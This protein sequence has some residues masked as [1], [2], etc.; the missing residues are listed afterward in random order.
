MARSA[1]YSRTRAATGDTVSA[2]A[3]GLSILQCFADAPAALSHGELARRTGIPK[4]TVTRLVATLVTHGL[5][6]PER[7]S[8]RYRLAAGVMTLA[9][10]FL[11]GLDTRAAARPHMQALAEEFDAS[12]YLAV[13]DAPEMVIIEACR[14]R[15]AALTSRL[16]IGSRVM[17]LRS[18]LG[19]AYLGGLDPAARESLLRD[20]R[21]RAGN[22]WRRESAGLDA[23]LRDAALRGYCLSLGES[24]PDISA[25]AVALR[26]SSGE[27]MTLNCGGP[28][29]RF[30]EEH[31]RR[32]VAPRLL[33]MARVIAAEIGAGEPLLAASA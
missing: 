12:V 3:R 5:L 2:L 30:G 27:I 20:L 17:L 32:R 19:R 4:P 22:A 1:T 14:T 23:A 21:E 24:H 8:E 6:R 31:L 33:A 25:V 26:T 16:D 18:A 10:A 15:T 9:R 7:D 29:F 28:A 13:C 11:S